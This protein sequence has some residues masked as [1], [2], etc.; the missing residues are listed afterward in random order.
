MPVLANKQN[1]L[2]NQKSTGGW[3]RPEDWLP[4]PTVVDTDDTFVGLHAIFPEGQ[5]YCAFRFTTSTGQY[6]V[7]WGD[8]TIDLVN[9][10][11]TAQHDYDYATYDPTDAT[12]SSR[13]YKQAI[14]TVTAVSGL[15]RTCSFQFRFVTSP[16]QNQIYTTGFLDCILSM[17]NANSG[18][19]IVFG[20]NLLRHSYVERFEVKTLGGCTNLNEFFRNCVSLEV[21]PLFDTSSVTIMTSMFSFCQRIKDIPTFNTINV[22]SMNSMFVSCTSLPT[23]PF[24]DTSNVTNM[25]SMFQGTSTLEEIP[26]LNTQ[27][28]E[29]MQ[30]MFQNSGIFEIP[31]LNTANV[32][33]TFQMLFSCVRLKRIPLFDTSNVTTMFNMFRFCQVLKYIPPLSTQS[34]TPTSGSN[35]G[36]EFA[37][38]CNSLE[39]CEMIFS[40]DV[41]LRGKLSQTALVEIFNNLVDRTST[42]SANIDIAGNWGAS[43][44]TT[45][46]RDI[47]LNKN[48]TITG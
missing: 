34:I 21:V 20:G 31:L 15:L 16:T 1:I 4:M 47:A 7:D 28:V 33:S 5:N 40:R 27:N 25:V 38:D 35:F 41:A 37:T 45:A 29:S 24:L 32:L 2:Y 30:S 9:S 36:T 26:L 6:R 11:V 19:S 43:A 42:T 17:P 3:R 22:T 10:N 8:G 14:I 46:E 44:L 23:I 48:W 39:R 18:A 12:L 13:G